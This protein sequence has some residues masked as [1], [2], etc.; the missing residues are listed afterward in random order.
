MAGEYQGAIEGLTGTLLHGWVWRP[1]V[2]DERVVLEVLLD[3][4]SLGVTVANLFDPA[5]RE[6]AIGDGIHAFSFG[7]PRL[8]RETGGSLVVKVANTNITIGE[9]CDVEQQINKLDSQVSSDGGLRLVGWAQELALPEKTLTIEISTDYGITLE[10]VADKFNA[11]AA[12]QHKFCGF[13]VTLPPQLADG[14]AHKV[15]LRTSDGQALK[16]SP[17][18]IACWL[19][20]DAGYF[21]RELAQQVPD[22]ATAEQFGKLLEENRH[23][24]PRSL[25]FEHYPEWFALFGA[26]REK[27]KTRQSGFTLYW[28]GE[29]D[30]SAREHTLKSLRAQ[31]HARWSFDKA[32]KYLVPIGVGDTL[33]PWALAAVADSIATAQAAGKAPGIVYT[34]CDHDDAAGGRSAPWFKP[35]WDPD[36]QCQQN[37][38]APLCAVAAD[39]I[40][41]EEKLAPETLPYQAA[42]A[43]E[44]CGRDIIHLPLVCYHHAHGSQYP[45]SENGEQAWRSLRHWGSTAAQQPKVSIIIPTRDQLD[46]L[47]RAIDS[48]RLQ[49]YANVEVMVMN[50]QSAKAD[51]LAYLDM[52]RME[53]TTVLDYDAPFNFAA[54]NNTA[55]AQAQGDVVCLL[56]ND[57]QLLTPDWLETMLS[58]LLRDD[59]GAVGAKLLWPNRMVQHGGVILGQNKVAG[60]YGNHCMD[61]DAGYFDHNQVTRRVSALT[62]ACLLLRKSDYHAVGGMNPIDFPVAFNDVD[63]CLKLRHQLGK[64][65]VW[66]PDALLYHFESVSRGKEDLPE[67]QARAQRE[68]NALRAHWGDVLLRDP[69][70]NP[71]LNLDALAG[72]HQGLA[73]PPRER[74][75]R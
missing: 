38:L 4:I 24:T 40:E 30:D 19:E 59:T 27:P 63:L 37:L 67:K 16:G 68:I 13:D 8:A 45:Q 42:L 18:T 61:V 51:T 58:L 73:F 20:G 25:G 7:V 1:D 36:L 23:Y 31:T 41:S 43:C 22:K 44:R 28:V 48:L 11:H 33:P 14:R 52:L 46:Y 32:H 39:L 65:C 53:G 71:N 57:V 26:P 50:N 3:G 47:Q 64:H 56:N 17:V 12:A 15:H 49:T 2:P 21:S 72:A 55:V 62:A 70:Y 75:W 9:P 66:T 74:T 69:A 5:L 29:G 35:A 6:R 34:D 60:H 54:M 10:Q